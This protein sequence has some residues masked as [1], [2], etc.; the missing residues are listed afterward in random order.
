MAAL[1]PFFLVSLL[2]ASCTNV[3]AVDIPYFSCLLEDN[4]QKEGDRVMDSSDATRPN[5]TASRSPYHRSDGPEI[6]RDLPVLGRRSAAVPS[7]NCWEFICHCD[8]FSSGVRL[9]NYVL[10]Y[11]VIV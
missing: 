5:I 10:Q 3:Y 7:D 1:S 8:R 9:A 4:T 11:V 6:F 2:S